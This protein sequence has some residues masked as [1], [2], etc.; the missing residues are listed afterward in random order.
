MTAPDASVKLL[1]AEGYTLPESGLARWKAVQ[2]AKPHCLTCGDPI[3]HCDER[4]PTPSGECSRC[5]PLFAN[6]VRFARWRRAERA[7]WAS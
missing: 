4:D 2:A 3:L 6:M 5:G 1:D 7:R